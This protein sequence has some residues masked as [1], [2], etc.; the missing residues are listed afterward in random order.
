LFAPDADTSRSEFPGPEPVA[1]ACHAALFDEAP[2]PRYLVVPNAEE[3]DLILAQAAHEWARLNA[4]TPHR[5]STERLVAEVDA[6]R[7]SASGSA[8]R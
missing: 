7:S 5:W 2:L 1:A 8:V 4:S 3:A 6:D